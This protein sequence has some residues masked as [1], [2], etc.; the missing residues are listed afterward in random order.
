MLF[1]EKYLFRSSS[2]F[3]KIFI[4]IYLTYNAALVSGMHQSDFAVYTYIRSFQVLFPYRL[5]QG[6]EYIS[7]YYT[8]GNVITSRSLLLIYFAYSSMC[9]LTS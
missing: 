8:Q 1:F 4:G 6:I 2:F 3:K 7:L 9:M 5:L